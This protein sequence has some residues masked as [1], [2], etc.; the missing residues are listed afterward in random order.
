MRARRRVILRDEE[1]VEA[2]MLDAVIEAN[3]RKIGYG[4]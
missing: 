1:Q 4:G 2:L 3:L